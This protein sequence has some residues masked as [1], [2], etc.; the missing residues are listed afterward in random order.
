MFS[1]TGDM[2]IQRKIEKA[3]ITVEKVEENTVVEPK[4]E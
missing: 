3:S 2:A 1:G 4:T